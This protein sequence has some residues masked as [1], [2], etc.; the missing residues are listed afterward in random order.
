MRRLLA[1][2]ALVLP[3][4]GCGPAEKADDDDDDDGGPVRVIGLSLDREIGGDDIRVTA[5]LTEDGVALPGV[6]VTIS[7]AGGVASAVTDA[8]GG[9]YLSTVVADELDSQVTITATAGAASATRIALPMT[10]V[11]EA[12][13]QPE[14]IAGLVNSPGWED[15][16]NI[17]PDGEWLIVTS[18]VPIDLLSCVQDGQSSSAA[19]CMDVIGPFA[20]P[21][22]PG[23]LGADRI[24][25]GTYDSECPDIGIPAGSGFAFPPVS[26]YGFRRQTDGSFA[27]PFVIG[28]DANGCLGPYGMAF[29]G[30]PAGN[31]AGI[32]FAFNDPIDAPDHLEDV[33]YAPITLGQP[34]M[35][36]DY[37]V[38]MSGIQ[39][40]GFTPT[41]IGPSLTNVQGNPAYTP[42][43]VLW[44]DES[45]GPNDRDLY[46]AA[47]TGT[48]PSVTAGTAFTIGASVPG[49]AEIQPH[50]DETTDSLLYMGPSGITSKTLTPSV[51]PSLPGSWSAP[52]VLVG[53]A[54]GHDIVAVGEPTISRSAGVTELYFVYVLQTANGYDANVGRVRAR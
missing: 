18:I 4:I 39:V 1:A 20:A 32:V 51:D 43:Y 30:A 13:G 10:N 28:F 26:A 33:W 38:G 31:G 37:S 21:E 11:D 3:T 24:H 29:T 53:A 50:F 54:P 5:H 15:G 23:F 2:V 16:A 49:E 14:A 41:Q 44:D 35:L 34:N 40:T 47:L 48:L 7:A 46:A 17:S 52:T 36:G 27:E 8:G 12:W 19:S 6:A 42:G 25:D 9:D 45:L 22:R